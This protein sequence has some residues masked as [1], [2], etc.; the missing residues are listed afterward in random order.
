MQRYLQ[1]LMPGF[2]DMFF[3]YLPIQFNSAYLM[4]IGNIELLLMY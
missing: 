2:K 1:R 3:V 4:A